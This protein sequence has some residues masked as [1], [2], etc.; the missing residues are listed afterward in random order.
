MRQSANRGGRAEAPRLGQFRWLVRLLM[1]GFLSIALVIPAAAEYRGVPHLYPGRDGTVKVAL[2]KSGVVPLKGP[3]KRISVGNPGIADIL[4][5]RNRELYVVGKALGTT[6]VVVWDNNEL[7]ADR[8]DVEVTHDLET[9]KVKLHELLPSEQ[10]KVHSAQERIILSG[11]ASNIVKM[12]AAEELAYS[13]LPECVA[14]E[15]NVVIRDATKGQPIVLQQGSKPARTGNQECKEGKVVNLIQVGGAQQVMLQVTVAEMARDVLKRFSS[16]FNFLYFGNS[17]K[18]G[19]VSG[20]AQFPNALTPDDLEVPIFGNLTGEDSPIGPVV[21]TFQPNTPTIGD[22][23]LFLS[24]LT[25]EFFFQAA[26]E[27]SRRKGLAKI[28]A[29]PTLTTITGQEAKFLSGGEF[30]IPVSQGLNNSVTIEFKEF[31][32]GLVFL[33]VV[34]DSGRINLD[35]NVSVSDLSNANS[36]ALDVPGTTSTFFIPSL[37]K[38]SAAS[39]V[40]LANGQTIGIA[41][42]INEN[43]RE[44]VDKL[45]GLGDIP[46]LGGLFR[47]QEFMS[48]QT[49]LVIFVTPQ[50]AKPIAPQQVR[51]PT[52]SFVPPSDLE[53]YLLGRLDEGPEAT[54]DSEEAS[55]DRD[56]PQD[57]P[58][59][60][61]FGHQL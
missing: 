50:L 25:G 5:L 17:A 48:G 6:N 57:A 18:A 45:P 58:E 15:S 30:P 23:G 1:C 33:P 16:D 43:I 22:K 44:F 32:V 60:G 38:R 2:Y 36:V 27:A 56:L 12:Q 8:F 53:F 19:G 4:I 61:R 47:S 52:D 14:P 21:D 20:G 11:E 54:G 29:E 9:L 24:Y 55:A 35:L 49:E 37:R 10:I 51:L 26:I 34:L 7:I 13:F 41:G 31:G 28:L 42:L 46:V 39:T 3:A 40:E 59:G